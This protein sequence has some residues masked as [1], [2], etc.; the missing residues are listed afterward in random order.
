MSAAMNHAGRRAAL[1]RR[2]TELDLGALLV[3]R[4]VNVRYLTGFTG[5]NGQLLATGDGGVFL[6]DSRYEDQARREVPDL[7]GRTYPRRLVPTLVEACRALAV[8]RLGFEATGVTFKTWRELDAMDGIELVPTE[9][10]VERLRWAKDGDELALIERAQLAADEAFDRVTGKLTEGI[11]EREVAFEL[12]AAMRDAGADAVGFPTIAAFG[13]NAAEPHH[14]PGD[15]SLAR[16]DVVKLDF[17]ARVDGYHSDMTRTVAFGEPDPR[18]REI[19]E[20]VQR[21]QE[22]G[23]AAVRAGARAG[24]ADTAARTVIREAGFGDRFGHSLGHGIGLEVHEGPTLR[25]GSE[26]V[27]PEGTVVTVEPGVYIPGL[28]GIRIEDMVVVEA[29]GCRALPR[30]PKDLLTL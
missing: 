12:E 4:L 5:S 14:G 1:A 15:R 22:A 27:L 8:K 25:D 29:G 7:E 9:E 18:L 2:L 19:H 10:D 28:G 21:A 26:D 20:V 11:T 6:T 24:D 17:G 23:A 3:T 13:E 16:G 30:T